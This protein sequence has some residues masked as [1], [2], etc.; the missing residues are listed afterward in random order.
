LAV[1]GAVL[2]G[3]L[4]SFG[5]FWHSAYKEAIM[6]SLLIPVL[7]EL[8]LLTFHVAGRAFR[9]DET[10]S[11]WTVAGLAVAGPHAG[12]RLRAM[13]YEVTYWF[14]WSAFRPETEVRR[15]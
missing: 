11:T 5:S 3:L 15:P 12:R 14:I 10:G 7:L 2:V 6:F 13:D 9:D 8:S 1:V 4:E